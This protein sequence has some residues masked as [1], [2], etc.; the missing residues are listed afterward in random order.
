MTPGQRVRLTKLPPG[1]VKLLKP[2]DIGVLESRNVLVHEAF[3]VWNVRFETMFG[4]H[5]FNVSEKEMECIPELPS[6][7]SR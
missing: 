5:S 4:P 1:I 7:S 2:G 3:P 6:H